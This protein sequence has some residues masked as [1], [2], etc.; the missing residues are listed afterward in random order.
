MRAT[1]DRKAA[2]ARRIGRT[3]LAELLLDVSNRLGMSRDLLEA[4]NVL[5][6]LTARAVGA[7][8]GAVFLN[9]AHT[10]EL[11][12]RV[13]EGKFSREIRM[14]NTVGIAGHVFTA[15]TGMI[16]DDAYSDPRFNRAVD[17]VTGYVTRN[18]LCV[19]LR[20]L[21]GET[22]GVA[23]LLNK[24]DGPFTTPDL[25]LLELMIEQ[26]AVAI[27]HHR[28]VESIEH[29]RQQELAFLGV[30]SEISSELKLGPLL[31]KLI[32][33]ITKMLDAE[34]STLFLN[35]E[36]KNELYTFVGEG[37]GSAQIRFPNDRG[38]AGAVFQSNE[39]INIPYAYA[40]L[41]FN[42]SFDKT[43]GFFT[44]SILC[45]PVVNKHGKV[46]GVTQVLN[47]R[48]G[49]FTAEDEARLKA[50]V[51]QISIGLENAALFDDIQNI[52]NYNV[53]ILES[54][55]NGVITLD[56]TQRIVTCNA[57]AHR[58]FQL[59]RDEIV[60]M[61]A[62]TFFTG[63]N[64]WVLDLV[65]TVDAKLEALGRQPMRRGSDRQSP[66]ESIMDA[67]LAVRDER[68][69]VNL[70]VLPLI[71]ISGA[72]M[73][74]M[75]L[76]EDISTEKRM[77]TTMSR[78]MDPTLADQLLKSGEALLGGQAST[79]TV[80]FSDIRSFT[81]LT[82][83]LGAQETVSFLNEYFT[84]MVECIQREGGMLDKF[85]GDAI[86]AVFGT[87]IAR[88]DDEDRA[89]R[90]A[91]GMLREL[92]AYNAERRA[93]GQRPIEIGV[94]INTDTIV[95]GNIGS[96]KRMDYTV[97]GDGVNLASRLEGA[98]KQYG[99]RILVTE[100]T[101]R[102]LHGTYRAREI[103]RIIV[104]GKTR[105]VSIYEI[106]EFHTPE[107]FPNIAE[108]CAHFRHGL[109]CYRS[110]RFPEALKAFKEA[111]RANPSDAGSAVYV[112]RCE[113]LIAHPPAEWHGVWVME[114]K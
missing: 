62:D 65:R 105:P 109:D 40:D 51:S 35:D 79:A 112:A 12:S 50:F 68:R 18:I 3:R 11:F 47:K 20:T 42:P 14:L 71:G 39:T 57:A 107:S 4:L 77:K 63:P 106:L 6:D 15:G 55:S 82:E 60:G 45:V 21:T 64:G 53:S 34:R 27:E 9:D 13:A 49:A 72:R 31:A 30:V 28:T 56:E 23:E 73:G 7:E 29:A 41:R 16:I 100:H 96:P 67:E 43:T 52:K 25:D 104:K 81:T 99:A 38:I 108:V 8:R 91:I 54:M 78:Y 58:L 48:G 19:P 90:A 70:S 74:S 93:A 24:H 103:D 110:A 33:T 97:I 111:C 44:R 22:L 102:R 26:A 69:S 84:L 87:P 61:T 1:P 46:I 66:Q 17:S 86:M 114:S 76:I 32:A 98:C 36:K 59:T 94:G 5:V 75:I 80:L 10:G 85:I 88:G 2:L 101:Y 83:E 95:S 37:L 92:T 89:V 113:Q